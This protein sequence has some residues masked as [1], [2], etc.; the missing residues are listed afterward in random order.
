MKKILFICL[1]NVCRSPM[2]AG[3]LTKKA[4]DKNIAMNADSA[5]FESYHIGDPADDRAVE[6]C[7]KHGVDI[8]GHRARLF[9]VK[10]FDDFD[11]IYAM[12][13]KHYKDARDFA[14]DDNDRSK[15][16][17]M[18]DLLEPGSNKSI[19]DPYLGDDH[20]CEHVYNL[21]EQA[22]DNLIEQTN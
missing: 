9:S 16:K 1:G 6:I 3:I 20:E 17:Y 21:L 7:K 13:F 10:D 5:G 15:V 11:L 12:D 14:R 22:V 8:S 4:H 2:A 19:P 18:M